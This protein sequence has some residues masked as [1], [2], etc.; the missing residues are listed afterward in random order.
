MAAKR[1]LFEQ[2]FWPPI[3]VSK[4]MTLNFSSVIAKRC[5]AYRKRPLFRDDMY[6]TEGT[7]AG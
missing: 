2:Y 5:D 6:H 3:V 7:I 1:D 4:T